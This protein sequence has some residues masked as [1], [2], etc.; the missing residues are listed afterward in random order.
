MLVFKLRLNDEC[1]HPSDVILLQHK[2]I[3]AKGIHE[4]NWNKLG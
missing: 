4:E 3:G 2:I 1:H